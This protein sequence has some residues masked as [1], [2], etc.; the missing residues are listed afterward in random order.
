MVELGFPALGIT[1][2]FALFA[3]AGTPAAIIDR[4]Y[5]DLV[6]IYGDPAFTRRIVE[7]SMN[8][9]LRSP[10]DFRQIMAADIERFGALLRQAGATRPT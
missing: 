1:T 2:W 5:G 4:I 6:A 7:R 3:P 10:A 9:F 8:P